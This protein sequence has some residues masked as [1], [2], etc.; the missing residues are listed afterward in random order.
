M[1]EDTIMK[2]KHETVLLSG[3]VDCLLGER[4]I[5]VGYDVCLLF[6]KGEL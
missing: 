1:R 6:E 3:D 4:D 5:C 2:C